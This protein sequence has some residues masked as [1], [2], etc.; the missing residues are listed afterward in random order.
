MAS[1]TERPWQKLYPQT[2]RDMSELPVL[3]LGDMLKSSR[4]RFADRTAMTFD[5][6]AWSYSDLFTHAHAFAWLLKSEGLSRG[7]R[8]AIALPNRPEY[9]IAVFGIVLAGGIVVQV[10]FRYPA[11]EIRRIL[12]D[13]GATF[14]VSDAQTGAKCGSEG[15]AVF[16]RRFVSIGNADAIVGEMA[17]TPSPVSFSR[18]AEFLDSGEA[19]SAAEPDDVAVLQYTGGTTGLAKGV[20]LTHR[21]LISNLEQRFALTYAVADL[22]EGSKTV[23]VLPMSHVFALTTI[24]LLAVRTGMNML[25]VPEFDAAKMLELIREERPAVFSGVPT[26]YTALLQQ[27]NVATSGLED[28]SIFNSAGAG[29][30]LEQIERFERKTGGRIIEGFGISEASPSTHINPAF[31]PRKVGSVGIPLPFTDVR[32]VDKDASDTAELPVGEVGEMIVRGPQ[33]TSG[34]W[35]NPEQTAAAIRDGWLLTGDLARM[36]EDGYFY[37]VGRKKEMIVTNGFNV[38]PAEVE[39]ILAKF[40][41]MVE[42]AVVG[43]PDERRGE[44]VV[45]Y[46]SIEPEASVSDD[47]ID[48]F[49]REQIAAYKVP[50]RYIRLPALPRTPVG[51]IAKNKLP[52]LA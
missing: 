19:A 17:R 42:S 25:L 44:A 22:P 14:V 51:K 33:V 38:Y 41:G 7:D 15:A 11:E 43:I 40:P 48:T 30:P 20:M 29:F 1:N 49:C 50:R 31:A 52:D 9:V 2:V 24:T 10:N 5:G 34:Y 46:I 32:V 3:T 21:N 23:D 6:S 26:M 37:I 18:L 47:E 39:Q 36:D 35:N 8:V 28:V 27:P 16:G 4:D 12:D 13:S 45:A